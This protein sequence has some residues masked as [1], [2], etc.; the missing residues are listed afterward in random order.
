MKKWIFAL[1]AL[2]LFCGCGRL[3]EPQR[4]QVGVIGTEMA[5]SRELA[6]K[7]IA[8]A[9]Y[10]P[11]ELAELETELD[12]SDLS[13]GDWVYPYAEGCVEQGFFVGSEEGTFRPQDELTLWEA[14]ALMDRLSPDYN[15]RIVLTDEN[16]NMAV[17]Y[18]LWVQLLQTALTSRGEGGSLADY[19]LREQSAVLLTEDGL[20]DTGRFTAA[21]MD[22]QPYAN[23]RITFLE[24]DGE[25]T[26]LLT[27]EA[28]SPML[29]NIYCRASEGQL[30]LETG[31]GVAAFPYR[32]ALDEGL[33]DVKLENGGIAEVQPL[34]SLGK[35]EVKRVSAQEIYLAEQGALPW[36]QDARIYDGRGAEWGNADFSDLICGTATAEYY[37]RD[38]E[39]CGAVL[40]EN[41][42]LENI[43]IFL[44]GAE[45]E[46]V[47]ISAEGGF[48]LSNAARSKEFAAGDAA[49]LT[50]DL[51]WFDEGIL[52]VH[53]DSPIRLTFADGASYAYPGIL[54]LERRSAESFS[55]VN[56]L[57]LEDYLPGVVAHEMP[58]SFGQVALEAQA[59]TARSYAYNQFYGNAYCE[60]GAHMTDTVASQVY[61]GDEQDE[62]ARAAV[63]NTAGL[64]VVTADG[65]V[66]QT[67]FYSTSC[68]FGASNAEVWSKD[69]SFGNA[70]KAY[71]QAKAYGDLIPPTSEEDWLA[72]WQNWEQEGYD[73]DSPWYRWKV[74]FS[75]GQ[76]SEIAAETLAKLEQNSPA[77]VLCKQEDGSFRAGL[78]QELGRLQGLSV[79]RRGA[80]GVAMELEMQF[81]RATLRVRTEYAIRQVLSPTRRTIGDEIYLQRKSGGTLTGYA[82]LPSGFFAAKEMRNAEGVLTGVAFYGGGNGHGV[83]MS[84]Y[85]A[86]WLAEQGKT[87]AEILA[88]YFPGTAVERVL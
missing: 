12:F 76:L 61:L 41:A 36:A 69:G 21:G 66:A 25:I 51:P 79:T 86:K 85:G 55:I 15:S 52:T 39:I 64:C 10:T 80:G 16:K 57:P 5:I 17:S 19:G 48:T 72:F 37:E 47:T 30:L 13:E 59:I 81:E 77:L 1:L 14:Q 82:L 31:A 2:L 3:D 83:G 4:A 28:L 11:Q 50:A 74:Y 46:R 49:T 67:Y 26:A 53:A 29:H 34:E 33:A 42:V 63:A 35:C 84:Q 38:G 40:R 78:P 9:F 54:E 8:L 44:R 58:V 22:L 45:Q 23:S 56:E 68:G 32:G 60:Y 43:R 20:C 6:A 62:T 87:A 24:K 88:E 7:M 27:V 65:R 18:E 75:C 70:A 71:L 73:R